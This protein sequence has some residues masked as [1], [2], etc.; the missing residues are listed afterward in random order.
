MSGVKH[1]HK[2]T[3]FS[4]VFKKIKDGIIPIFVF[5]ISSA[6]EF[7][8]KYG[9]SYTAVLVV[10]VFLIVIIGLAIVGWNK[11]TYCI[12]DEGIYIKNG[13]FQV[14]ER[15][16]PFSQ[17]HTADI[18]SLI[19][20]RL[21]NVCKLDI[22]TAG[23]KAKESEISILLSNQ[24]GLRVKSLIF[25]EN[26]MRTEE[27]VAITAKKLTT[28]TKD[29]FVMASM[30]SNMVAGIF[31]IIA[32][33]S[34]VVDK[35]PDAVKRK[36]KVF[37]NNVIKDVNSKGMITYIVAL[38]LAALF[39]SWSVSVI[40]TVIKYYGFTVT[41]E[42]D[43]IKLSY[44]LLNKKEVT[45]PVKRIQ[46]ITIVEGIIKKSFG[47]FSLNVETIGYGKD[48]GE[49]TMLCP[50]AKKKV[51]DNFFQDIL[52]EMNINY[53][54]VKSPR[55][56]LKGFI[57]FR[58]VDDIIIMSIIAIFVPYGQFVFILLPVIAIWNYIR[59]I[60][61]GIYFDNDFIV[62]RYRRSA[63]ETVIIQKEC[64]QSIERRQN[65]FQKRK[66]VAK[67][68]V[69]IAGDIL[70]KSYTVGYIS[71]NYLEDILYSE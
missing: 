44:G 19:V 62:M 11:N 7:L 40:I 4:E 53:D 13:I 25:K 57:L 14:H 32:F 65:I 18:S 50:I 45:I 6:S 42:E 21:F 51:L 66:A 43:Y 10:V 56:A 59:F 61:N 64:I 63:R 8:K 55:K 68:K 20:Q 52:P 16:V 2:F 71:Q 49:S 17:V 38:I 46:S 22:D 67:Y 58:L 15:T 1:T 28:S 41:R 29:L 33:Y 54:L 23:G 35:I 24:E 37:S 47:Y 69:N 3:I 9:G 26:K 27:E 34:N 39:I 60:D 48:K 31:I 5:L 70:G 30:S 12:Q 36:A